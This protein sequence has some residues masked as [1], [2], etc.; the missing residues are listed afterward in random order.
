[1]ERFLEHIRNT[2]A[3]WHLFTHPAYMQFVTSCVFVEYY[4]YQRKESAIGK[5]FD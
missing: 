5:T 1:M 2:A 4:Y 3:V